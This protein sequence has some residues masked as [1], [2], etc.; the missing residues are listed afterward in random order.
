MAYWEQMTMTF[1]LKK[2][3]KYFEAPYFRQYMY[4][5]NRKPN[6]RALMKNIKFNC[7]VMILNSEQLKGLNVG[8]H[9]KFPS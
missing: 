6:Y 8:H 2:N 7:L 1:V 3:W 5:Y 4:M 9:N